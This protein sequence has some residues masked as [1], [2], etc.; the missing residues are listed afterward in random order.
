MINALETCIAPR[1]PL[2]GLALAVVLG[3]VAGATG[4]F[5]FGFLFFGALFFLFLAGLFYR[6][7][8]AIP[9]VFGAVVLVA[10]CRF[11]AVSEPLSAAEMDRLLPQ[12]PLSNV[13]LVGRVA[14]VP[15][16][17][18]YGSGS[19]GSWTLHFDCTGA[20]HSG[21]WENYRGRIQISISGGDSAKGFRQGE[22]IHFSGELRRR[23][24]PGG[25]PIEL[26]LPASRGWDVLDEPPHFSP[27]IW[28]QWLREIAAQT[29]SNGMKEYPAQLAVY[30][31]LLLG[32]RKAIPP[33]THQRFRRTGTLHIFA[34]SGLHVGI[35]GMLIIA[36][37][38]T[39]GLPRDRWGH[40]LLPLL[41]AYVVATGMKSSALRAF[42]MAAVYFL[43]PL[44]RRKPDIPTSIAF[45]AIL[46]LFINPLEIRSI[47]FIYSFTVVCFIVM[48]FS[49]VPQGFIF[50]GKG[51]RRAVR[52]YL[53]SLGVTSLAA[54][55][56]S[57]PLTA[58]LFG[59]Y[60]MVS[61][62]ANLVVVP[63]TFCIVLSGWL[64]ILVPPA[65]EI[66]N[67]AA[68]V[69]INGQLS[70]VR[71]LG[72]LPGAYGFIPPPPLTAVLF[73][74]A[75]WIALFTARQRTTA[76]GLIVLA[77]VTAF[78]STRV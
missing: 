51:W 32:Y 19:R 39:V 20:N 50:R 47:G 66:F 43:S 40:W 38:Q 46:L 22:R 74:Y 10:A 30:K 73:W 6:T 75:G 28:G 8:I 34:I 55:I 76:F 27:V 16:F 21:H 68:L 64:A 33:E 29:L 62:L 41:L 77:L 18:A 69:F 24:F 67:H 14:G 61:L 15:K 9:S 45:A 60:S 44:F 56:A 42:T 49:A 52:A 1:R 70:T 63:L 17:H 23:D 59:T 37:L 78:I 11:V 53:L 3:M 71:V 7:N 12:L 31:A 72:G 13:Q 65:S 26:E 48:V 2:V 25:E 36:V 35:V 58:L 54:L 5:S 57:I 4:L